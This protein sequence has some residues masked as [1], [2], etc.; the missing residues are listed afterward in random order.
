MPTSMSVCF[1]VGCTK[2]LFIIG[3][4]VYVCTVHM[5][6]CIIVNMIYA[7]LGYFL[8]ALW[9]KLMGLALSGVMCSIS[10]LSDLCFIL[11]STVQFVLML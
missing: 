8:L 11:Y 5:D 4:V 6:V 1:V 3:P 2:Y 10:D 7:Y 9:A